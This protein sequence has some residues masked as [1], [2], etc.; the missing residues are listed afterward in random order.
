MHV[1]HQQQSADFFV[2]ADKMGPIRCMSRQVIAE[3]SRLTVLHTVGSHS[4]EGFHRSSL[5]LIVP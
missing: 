4:C 3:L 2:S 1:I 5:R